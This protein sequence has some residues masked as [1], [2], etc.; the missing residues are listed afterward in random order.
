[1]ARLGGYGGA[2]LVTVRR[3]KAGCGEAV[4]AE[5]G[6]ARRGPAGQGKAVKHL[7]ITRRK[8]CLIKVIDKG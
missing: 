7:I 8:T 3:G 1:M 6:E 4:V 2:W 5:P